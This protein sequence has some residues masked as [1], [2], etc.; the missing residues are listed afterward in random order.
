MLLEMIVHRIL[1][2]LRH[3][4]NRTHIFPRR[5]LCVC[6]R[7]FAY[8]PRVP[9]AASIFPRPQAI[10]TACRNGYCALRSNTPPLKS[11]PLWSNNSHHDSLLRPTPL[12]P[13]PGHNTVNRT[14]YHIPSTK[15]GR[16]RPLHERSPS[17]RG[18][19][20]ICSYT[21]HLSDTSVDTMDTVSHRRT[22]AFPYRRKER[23]MFKYNGPHTYF[24]DWRR[25][26]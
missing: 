25:F 4:T 9:G 1:I 21:P 20:R 16:I 12:F 13:W 5:V 7:H 19:M 11:R 24:G 18:R 8:L 15:S 2:L 22:R 23:P 3:L 10:T 26:P 17:F 14:S 6:V